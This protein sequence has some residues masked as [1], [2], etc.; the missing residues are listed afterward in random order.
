[1]ETVRRA[2]DSE[3]NRIKFA[4]YDGDFV[5]DI[6]IG[7][8]LTKIVDPC[9]RCQRGPVCHSAIRDGCKRRAKYLKIIS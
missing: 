6:P 3:G 1:M 2:Y 7:Y 5:C 4:I 9:G 8:V